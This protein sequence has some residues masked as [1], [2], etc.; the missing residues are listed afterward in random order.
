VCWILNL[1]GFKIFFLFCTWFDWLPRLVLTRQIL[2]ELKAEQCHW[3][4][5]NFL[6]RIPTSIFFHPHRFCEGKV[7]KSETKPWEIIQAFHR[8]INIA[9][10]SCMRISIHHLV[11]LK[12]E[13]KR[14]VSN[15]ISVSVIMVD[16]Q[17]AK[18]MVMHAN[19]WTEITFWWS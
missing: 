17:R 12:F 10:T 19:T 9:V 15:Y 16:D 6:P 1:P 13:I 7:H 18:V 3:Q 5:N 8:T 4:T 2:H 14:I 11:I